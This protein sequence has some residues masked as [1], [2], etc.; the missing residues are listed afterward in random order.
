M[1]NEEAVNDMLLEYR[2]LD[3]KI[4]ALSFVAREFRI[5]SKKSFD[6]GKQTAYL[7]RLKGERAEIYNLLS[8]EFE[9]IDNDVIA[10]AITNS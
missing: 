9:A 7:E 1:V 3:T 10:K 5:F 4:E 8:A 2:K 6:T